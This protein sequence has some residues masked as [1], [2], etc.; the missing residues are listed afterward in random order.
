MSAE[1]TSDRIDIVGGVYREACMRPGWKEVFGSAGRAAV[2]MATMGSKC[3]LHTYLDAHTADPMAAHSALADIELQGTTITE[4]G[5]FDYTHCLA[6][7]RVC[8]PVGAVNPI[9]VR[10]QQVVRFG[11]L[12][13]EAI[14]HADEAVYDPQNAYKPAFFHGN[15]STAKR[16]ALVLNRHEATLMTGLR[17]ASVEEMAEAL[18]V[19]GQAQ[20]VVIKQG[21]LGAHVREGNHS[22][23]VPAYKSGNVWKL[24]SG[25][26][27]VGHFAHQWMTQ[28][29]SAPQSALL[30]SQA[31][32]YYC[33][34]RGFAS[35]A[36]LAKF[37]LPAITPS[38]RFIAGRRPKVYLAGPFFGL[39]QVWMVEEARQALRGMGLQVF[40]P[41]HDVG[42][43][44]AADVASKDLAAIRDADVLFAISDGLDPGT[45]YEIGYANS[46]GKP[47]VM[48]C[49]NESERNLKMMNGAGCQIFDDF[50][51]AIYN[52]A[53]TACEL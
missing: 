7:P 22:E 29:R 3:R 49:E 43:A 46:L 30:A 24:G 19:G 18:I 26:N 21:P 14:V 35:A 47:V 40:S 8:D 52:T 50:V 25:D 10:G 1:A 32:A 53:W 48:Y 36:T 27:F 34:T 41:Y 39:A 20:V 13:N 16:L 12:E 17:G 51:S 5:I 38:A 11:M 31:T 9:T 37:Q 42:H 33:G 28:G 6:T 4:S 15:G 44:S 45:M 2:A 23:N